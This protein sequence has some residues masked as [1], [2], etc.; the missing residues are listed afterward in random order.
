MERGGAWRPVNAL[1]AAHICVLLREIPAVFSRTYMCMQL[2]IICR[3]WMQL[4]TIRYQNIIS[5]V[6]LVDGNRSIC[7]PK[8]L[9]REISCGRIWSKLAHFEPGPDPF[10]HKRV[11]QSGCKKTLLSAEEVSPRGEKDCTMP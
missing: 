10:S 5:Y 8:P 2:E 1:L 6:G 9:S 11:H 3:L 7:S 4:M